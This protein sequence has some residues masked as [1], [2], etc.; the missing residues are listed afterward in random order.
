MD[1]KYNLLI[2]EDNINELNIMS[3]FLSKKNIF[4][5]IKTAN[6][7]ENAIELAKKYKPDIVLLDIVMPGI[8]GISVL[9]SFKKNNIKTKVIIISALSVNPITLN[10]MKL[11]ALYYMVKPFDLDVVYERILNVLS[12]IEDDNILMRIS[13]YLQLLGIS[14]SLKGYNYLRD[15]I[16]YFISHKEEDIQLK[17]IYEEIAKRKGLSYKSVERA[18]ENAIDTAMKK[19][20]TNTYFE[21]FGNTINDIR[22]KPTAREFITTV[23]D[24]ILLED[25]SYNYRI[26]EH[27]A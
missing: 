19:N 23:V 16:F 4:N 9:E 11:G 22:C 5:T 15:S 7:G 10:T 3:S 27:Q 24:K 17:T 14:T 8:D 18:I 25:N 21:F 1:K 13:S 6:N 12:I 20:T 2:V 26:L